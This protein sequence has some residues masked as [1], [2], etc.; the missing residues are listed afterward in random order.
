LYNPTHQFEPQALDSF[1]F[2]GPED[3]SGAEIRFQGESLNG[4]S[5]SSVSLITGSSSSMFDITDDAFT[6]LSDGSN[7]LASHIPIS[8]DSVIFNPNVFNSNS[9]TRWNDNIILESQGSSPNLLADW[10]LPPPQMVPSAT[11]SPLGYSTSLEGLS[12]RYV[13]D[14][15]DILDLAPHTTGDR[16]IR[17][18]MG[19]RQSKVVSDLA[20]RQQHQHGTS[21]LSDESLKMVGRSSVEIDNTARDH[22]LYQNVTPKADGLY[23]CPWEGQDGCQHKPEKL[24]CNYEYDIFQL[25]FLVPQLLTSSC[26]AANPWIPI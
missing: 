3:I 13:L 7:N 6:S 24:K 4:V 21:D 11:N 5:H 16:V 18:P 12:P 20:S 8:Q 23:H 1:S 19:P 9:P 15:P 10:A 2:S 26:L 25:H 22:P 17:K 14:F